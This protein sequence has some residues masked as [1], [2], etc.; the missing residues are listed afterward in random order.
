MLLVTLHD[1]TPALADE[2]RAL[3]ALCRA[4]GIVP[5]LLVVPNWHGAAPLESDREFLD[6][7]RAAQDAGAEIFLHGERHDEAGMPRAWR[8][9]WRAVGRTAGEGEFL[10]LDRAGAS[11]RIARGLECLARVQ[12]T[13]IG[14]VPPAW[15]ARPATFDAAAAAGLAVSED[16][17][18][19]RLLQQA[20]VVLSPVVRWSARSAWRA[21]GSVCMA[22]AR[23]RVQR[24]ATPVRLALHPGDLR[25]AA[26]A[27]SVERSLDRWRDVHAPS[28]YAALLG[29]ACA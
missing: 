16:V 13:P 21:Y 19:I 1:V 26:S 3:W 23:W 14:F 22:E 15:L 12:L 7:L 10:T 6:W 27:R 17:A 25:H 18:G 11:A 4:R 28:G 29:A 2:T 24:T 20:R 5:G 8:D 9:S